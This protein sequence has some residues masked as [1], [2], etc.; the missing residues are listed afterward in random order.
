[1]EFR[2]AAARRERL[3]QGLAVYPEVVERMLEA[4]FAAGVD[5]TLLATAAEVADPALAEV[6][7]A[8]LGPARYSSV[9][10]PPDEARTVELAQ[11]VGFPGPI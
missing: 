1:V 3:R 5:A 4:T 11:E 9:V 7:E 10:A 8:A 2:E 6:V